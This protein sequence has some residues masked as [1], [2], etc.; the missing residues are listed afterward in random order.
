MDAI[1][2]P[3]QYVVGRA[4]VNH[5]ALYP[6]VGKQMSEA[7]CLVV[8]LSDYLSVSVCVCPCALV[9]RNPPLDCPCLFE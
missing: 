2:H 6:D 3:G 5:S 8:G 7:I 9:E 4:A 1:K